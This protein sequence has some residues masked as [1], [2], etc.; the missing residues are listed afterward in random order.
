MGAP[1]E[2]HRV[3]VKFALL[4]TNL[5]DANLVAIFIAEELLNILA[6]FNAGA[7][8]FLPAYRF[9][10]FNGIINLFFKC[11]DLLGTKRTRIKVETQA[12]TTD[13]GTLLRRVGR[14]DFMQCP[15][16]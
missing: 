6:V 5:N 1:A 9:A 2:F 3:T 7:G 15:V 12:V 14:D 16:E 10:C 11:I 8:H 4:S 13:H